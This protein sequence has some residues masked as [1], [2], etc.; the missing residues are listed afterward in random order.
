[1]QQLSLQIDR[2]E[3]ELSK[4]FDIVRDAERSV[5][6]EDVLGKI[7][8]GFAGLIPFDRIGCAFLSPDGAVLTAYWARS[9][10]GKARIAPGFSQPIA[11]SSLKQVLASGRPRIIN[12]LLA[13]RD[14]HPSSY[15]TRLIVDEGGR[16]SL[17]CPLVSGDRAIGF[18]FF[19]SRKPAAY[20]DLH[21]DL[22][23][24][25]AAQVSAVIEKSRLFERLIGRYRQLADRRKQLA[26]AAAI[27]PLTGVHNRRGL[28]EV[29]ARELKRGAGGVMAFI[30][31]DIDHFK[32]IND[33]HGHPAGDVLL[34][35]VAQRLLGALRRGDSIA[36][37]GGEEF[38]VVALGADRDEAVQLAERL[39]AAVADVSF[40]AGDL[41]ISATASFGVAVGA[42]DN[43]AAVTALITR[44]D[45][46]LYAAKAAGRN[47]V[48]AAE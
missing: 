1:M 4:L 11:E 5:L 12:D 16:S 24:Q 39:R 29:I 6:I 26:A 34:K 15:S 43:E 44:A 36:R 7:F 8:V 9:K 19:T 45:A 48:V 17:T 23:L 30:M 18:I 25:I 10:L 22:F 41:S 3:A 38:L 21:Q 46:A 42:P 40:S 13:Y 47:R 32:K 28:A 37:Y 31:L 27:D 33:R 14:E 2:R 35:G 20:R